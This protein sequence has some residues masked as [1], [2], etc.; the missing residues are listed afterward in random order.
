MFYIN[1]KEGGCLLGA[2]SSPRSLTTPQQP[3]DLSFFKYKKLSSAE[4]I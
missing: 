1:K 3:N 4:K 2:E